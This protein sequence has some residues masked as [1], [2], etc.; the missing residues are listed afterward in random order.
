MKIPLLS[1][2]LLPMLFLFGGCTPEN[3]LEEATLTLSESGTITFTKEAS[4]KVITIETNQAQ[5]VATSNASW[6]TTTAEG[7][8]LTIKAESNETLRERKG[9]VVVSVGRAQQVLKVVQSQSGLVIQFYPETITSNQ[10]G[11]K[12]A[13]DVI[14]NSNTWTAETDADWLKIDAIP[15]ARSMNIEV[16]ENTSPEPRRAKIKLSL[17]DGGEEQ[18]FWIAQEGIMYYIMPFM[19]FAD[20]SRQSIKLY[21]QR[22]R[23]LQTYENASTGW[24]DFTTQSPAF[25]DVSYTIYHQNAL[26]HAQLSASS[27]EMLQGEHL[28]QVIEMLRANGF[29]EERTTERV[30]Y[31]PEKRVLCEIKPD[32]GTTPHILF[33][34]QPKQPQAYP[35][36]EAFPYPFGTDT[37]VDKQVMFA[38]VEAYEAAHGGKERY[39]LTYNK[40][41]YLQFAIYDNDNTAEPTRAYF[42]TEDKPDVLET[43]VRYFSNMNKAFWDYRG[44]PLFT[45]EFMA[46]ATREGFV[47]ERLDRIDRNRHVFSHK[48][49]NVEMRI[50][51]DKYSGMKEHQVILRMTTPVH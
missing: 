50:H 17:Q 47:Y 41:G 8:R 13:V 43:S 48:T 28:R 46:L 18:E 27:K 35:T 2:V 32:Y 33:T 51:W 26:L 1:F 37:S 19:D 24:L 36:F 6:L 20:G 40:T 22:R 21:E 29:T 34:Y 10:W 39:R 11:G 23:S 31:N 45:E 9:S 25:P 16:Y 30:Y 5:W 15:S 38:E 12:Y 42:F 49:R 14:A 7:N 4:E 3:D 44:Y